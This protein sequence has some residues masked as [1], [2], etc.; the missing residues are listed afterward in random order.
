MTQQLENIEQAIVFCQ[1]QDDPDLWNDLIQD[2]LPRPGKIFQSLSY[3]S[4]LKAV[5]CAKN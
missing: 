1:E 2:S 3:L 4:Q 5:I